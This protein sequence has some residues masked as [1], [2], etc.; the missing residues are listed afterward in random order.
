MA[1]SCFRFCFIGVFCR[2]IVVVVLWLCRVLTFILCLKLCCVFRVYVN[3]Y[4]GITKELLSVL[5]VIRTI[6]CV[7]LVFVSLCHLLTVLTDTYNVSVVTYLVGCP[8]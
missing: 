5:I 6:I 8:G 7:V 3:A 2:D 4:Y 1:F